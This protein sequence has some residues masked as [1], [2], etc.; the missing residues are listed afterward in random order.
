MQTGAAAWNRPSHKRHRGDGPTGSTVRL[1]NAVGNH[2]P[3]ELISARLRPGTLE[4]PAAATAV[5]RVKP[6]TDEPIV[7]AS[8]LPSEHTPRFDLILS[9]HAL[10]YVGDLKPCARRLLTLLSPG[11]LMLIAMAGWD[12]TLMRLWKT[13]FALVNRPVPYNSA[14]DLEAI[15][16][17]VEATYRKAR[18]PYEIR[19][20]DSE[21]NRMSILR[22]LFGEH[23][24]DMPRDRLLAEFDPYVRANQIEIS[25]HSD[26]YALSARVSKTLGAPLRSDCRP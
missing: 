20:P 4:S 18:S 22:F 13:G 9:N 14:E 12:N 17:L 2:A 6:L 19:F 3:P 23:L 7:Q 21:E 24:R 10:Y 25:T 11:G 15:L 16:D 5:A 8:E 26:H 1:I